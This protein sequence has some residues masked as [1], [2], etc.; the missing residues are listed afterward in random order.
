[1][2]APPA[3]DRPWGFIAVIGVIALLAVGLLVVPG[4]LSPPAP[5]APRPS[6]APDAHIVTTDAGTL[7]FGLEGS[8]IVVHWTANGAATIELGRSELPAALVPAATDEPI[9]GSAE[10]TMTCLASSGAPTRIIF[11]HIGFGK[12]IEYSGPAAVGQGA[13]DGL[14]LF[15]LTGGT[16]AP[17]ARIEIKSTAGAVG[18]GAQSF[19]STL[20]DGLRQASGCRVLG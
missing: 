13:P 10:W 19:D 14:F 4:I 2:E 6:P 16:F 1:M 9:E 15:A 17:E 20:T 8:A 3:A 7:D 11:G 5:S 18:V 12:G